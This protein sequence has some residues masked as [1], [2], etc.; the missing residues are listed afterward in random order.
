VYF[1]DK[2]RKRTFHVSTRNRIDS[3]V[4][5]QIYTTHEYN[6]KFLK[7]YV[8]L[9]TYFNDVVAWKRK[10]L[11][12]D[13]GANIGL[14]TRYFAETFPLSTVLALEPQ[15]ENWL[16]I[17]ENCQGFSNVEPLNSAIGGKRGYVMIEN[18]KVENDAYRTT[19][20]NDSIGVEVITI[21]DLYKSD[22]SFVPF[23]VKIDIEGF[24]N[25]LFADNL[26]WIDNLISRQYYTYTGG[27]TPK[28]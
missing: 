11:I 15:R 19:R 8:E 9:T 27:V 2:E 16:K 10:P 14:S 25:D 17:L 21:N 5:D 20:T 7:A 22:Q 6:I 23:I 28:A 18:Q 12:I 1:F 4:A 26:E 13:C 3:R 24:E